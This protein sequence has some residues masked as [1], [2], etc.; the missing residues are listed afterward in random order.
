MP[1]C[2]LFCPIYSVSFWAIVQKFLF[3]SILQRSTFSKIFLGR[4]H[5]SWTTWFS[6]VA[7][8]AVNFT[9]LP[10]REHPIRLP[11][12]I[13]QPSQSHLWRNYLIHLSHIL[14]S[15]TLVSNASVDEGVGCASRAVCESVRKLPRIKV[16][17]AYKPPQCRNQCCSSCGHR[18]HVEWAAGHRESRRGW[19]LHGRAT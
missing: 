19:P 9:T 4:A 13:R 10:C 1:Q 18:H 7:G 8:Q 17:D 15:H 5:P 2:C 14:C 3:V 6:N 16:A 11:L 12:P